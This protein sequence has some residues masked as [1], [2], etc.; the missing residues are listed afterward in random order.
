MG[1]GPARLDTEKEAPAG[2]RIPVA[3][4]TV[5]SSAAAAA[6]VLVEDTCQAAAALAARKDLDT[7]ADSLAGA[8]NLAVA[9]S[10][11]AADIPAAAD[12]PAVADIPVAL[13]AEDVE[14][15]ALAAAEV[16]AAEL[17]AVAPQ[18]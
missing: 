17:E 9:G 8:D 1:Q 12:N 18:A 14:G 11:A 3:R 7:E 5:N 13:L 15:R 2:P 16:A 6:E 10:L 4:E